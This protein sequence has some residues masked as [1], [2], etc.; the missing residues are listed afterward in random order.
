MFETEKFEHVGSH[1]RCLI[2]RKQV[3]LEPGFAM[4]VHKEQGQMMQMER[5][6]VDPSGYTG[7]EQPYVM[8]SRATSLA[9][10]RVPRNIDSEQVSKRMSEDLRYLF[11][12]AFARVIPEGFHVE[13]SAKMGSNIYNRSWALPLAGPKDYN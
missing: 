13:M 1:R 3:P 4:T 12:L 10:L 6:I 8:V 5:M 11:E 9:G 2:K 7:T